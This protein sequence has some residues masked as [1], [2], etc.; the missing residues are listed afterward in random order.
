MWLALVESLIGCLW[1]AVFYILISWPWGICKD[2]GWDFGL[3]IWAQAVRGTPLTWPSCLRSLTGDGGDQCTCDCF[4]FCE[5][6]S[7]IHSVSPL[8]VCCTSANVRFAHLGGRD[9]SCGKS[10]KCG[11]G[12]Q[13]CCGPQ[14]LT[15]IYYP[16]KCQFLFIP[17][18]SSLLAYSCGLHYLKRVDFDTRHAWAGLG[19]SSATAKTNVAL[20][21]Y[22]DLWSLGS[23]HQE[24]F[25]G[26]VVVKIQ[27]EYAKS[28]QC[29]STR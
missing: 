3:L 12:V 1:L 2:K 24:G 9:S 27:W 10:P 26:R 16:N 20:G 17:L 15:G 5:I 18:P 14:R 21:G 19:P 25:S 28:D 7:L 11:K 6:Y 22:P 4:C 29:I 23:P 8:C 13:R